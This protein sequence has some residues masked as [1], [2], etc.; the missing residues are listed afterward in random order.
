MILVFGVAGVL[1]AG[2]TAYAFATSDDGVQG[3][4]AQRAT[5]AAID[6]AGGGSITELEAD[7]GGYDVEVVTDDGRKVDV[8]LGSDFQVLHTDPDDDTDD[9]T[10]DDTDDDTDDLS[11]ADADYQPA[12]DAALAE[13]G[14]GTVVDA[15]RDG[16]GYDVEVRFADGTS[17]EVELAADFTVVR[18]EADD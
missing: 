16:A 15:E 11:T 17:L 6:A 10:D 5:D 14:G 12:A 3:D 4:D 13:A 1:T 9:N 2:G 8:V 7:D 18:T